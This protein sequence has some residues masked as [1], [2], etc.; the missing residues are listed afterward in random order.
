MFENMQM[1]LL[2]LTY[3]VWSTTKRYIFYVFASFFSVV[4]FIGMRRMLSLQHF[5]DSSIQRLWEYTKDSHELVVSAAYK[6]L[7][8]FPYSTIRYYHLPDK[9]SVVFACVYA[10]TFIACMGV[11]VHRCTCKG[12]LVVCDGSFQS[13]DHNFMQAKS[14]NIEQTRGLFK[15]LI[16]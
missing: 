6:A 10:C 1:Y 8:A 4:V 12:V 2:T 15:E 14:D 13:I 11:C 3:S 16:L 9:V 7:S 5:R